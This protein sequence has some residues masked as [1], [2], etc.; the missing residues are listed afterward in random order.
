MTPVEIATTLSRLGYKRSRTGLEG[1]Y[2]R[3]NAKG[4]NKKR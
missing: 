4:L 3:Y 2:K 1:A